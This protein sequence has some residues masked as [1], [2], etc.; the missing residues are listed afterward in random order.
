MKQKRTKKTRTEQ[1]TN[2]GPQENRQAGY[3]KNQR[4]NSFLLSSGC[5]PHKNKKAGK[6]QRKCKRAD[7]IQE[8]ITGQNKIQDEVHRNMRKRRPG[9]RKEKGKEEEKIGLVFLIIY[10]CERRASARNIANN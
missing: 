9:G 8:L 4:N 1:A 10:E 5:L 3:T 7:S 6:V 2:Q